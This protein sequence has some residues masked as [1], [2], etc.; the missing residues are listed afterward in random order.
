MSKGGYPYKLC[1][2]ILP[3]AAV[4]VLPGQDL[5]TDQRLSLLTAGNPQPLSTRLASHSLQW[6]LPRKQHRKRPCVLPLFPRACRLQRP[7][8]LCFTADVL[9]C[10]LVLAGHRL[11]SLISALRRLAIFACTPHEPRT[12]RTDSFAGD[13][14]TDCLLKIAAACVLLLMC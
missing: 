8:P 11:H 12:N 2:F 3:G 1:R 9:L 13:F 5:M 10:C 14:E 4:S 6:S 7:A